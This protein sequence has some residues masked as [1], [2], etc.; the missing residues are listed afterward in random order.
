MLHE[1]DDVLVMQLMQDSKSVIDLQNNGQRNKQ[2]TRHLTI[3]NWWVKEFVELGLAT[4]VWISTNEMLADFLTKSK[5]GKFFM[6]CWRTV[7]GPLYDCCCK[8]NQKIIDR[9]CLEKLDMYG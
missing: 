2:R 5:H 3:R 1:N 8:I 7:T 6:Y 9:R 4:I